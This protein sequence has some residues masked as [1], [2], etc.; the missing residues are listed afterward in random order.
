MPKF[1]IPVIMTVEAA[2]I[3]E[4]RQRA[5]KAVEAVNETAK[6][7]CDGADGSVVA[8]NMEN[9]ELNMADDSIT[10]R[11]NRRFVILHPNDVDASYSPEEYEA[12]LEGEDD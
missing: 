6:Y 4:A 5:Y 10:D 11:V 9:I 12:A 3:D 8:D 7:S 1:D 2:T